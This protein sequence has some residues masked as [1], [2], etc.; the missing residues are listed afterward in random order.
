MSTFFTRVTSIRT[1]WKIS[2]RGENRKEKEEEEEVQVE[3]CNT[4]THTH[5]YI[6]MKFTHRMSERV[7]MKK[8]CNLEHITHIVEPRVNIEI[9]D[10]FSNK[11]KGTKRKELKSIFNI[12]IASKNVQ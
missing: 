3:K 2:H 9:C 7:N 10:F 12:E 6:H 11:M 1:T 5:I 8:V 4:D